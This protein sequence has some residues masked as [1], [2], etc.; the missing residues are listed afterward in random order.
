MRR[1]FMLVA[2]MVSCLS[3]ARTVKVA[4]ATDGQSVADLLVKDDLPAA[5]REIERM[6]RFEL[7][8]PTKAKMADDIARIHNRYG[9]FHSKTLVEVAKASDHLRRETWLLTTPTY[10]LRLQLVF[11]VDAE[12]GPVLELFRWDADLWDMPWQTDTSK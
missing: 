10:A 2:L 12:D 7:D 9:N 4:P 8:G 6:T 5:I 11:Y 3:A 1:T